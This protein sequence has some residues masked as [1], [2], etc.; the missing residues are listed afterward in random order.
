[1]RAAWGVVLVL[2]LAGSSGSAA[3]AAVF[4][5]TT[6]ITITD[7]AASSPYG[8]AIQ[9]AGQ[10]GRVSRVGVELVGAQHDFIAD[11]RVLLVAPT[12]KAMVLDRQ[13]GLNDLPTGNLRI[14]TDSEA[15]TFTDD[16]DTGVH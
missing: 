9:V 11:V 3:S 16:P 1:M 2:V 8:T 5:N 15:K 7:N 13:G 10:T 14:D 6:P 12:G 4:S